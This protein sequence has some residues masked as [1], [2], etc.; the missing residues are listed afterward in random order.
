M[1]LHPKTLIFLFGSECRCDWRPLAR[2]RSP[3][4][5]QHRSLC[6]G[7][8]G[9]YRRPAWKEPNSAF[10]GRNLSRE[11][12]A[13]L[14]WWWRI[15]LHRD[16]ARWWRGFAGGSS[17]SGNIT[18]AARTATRTRRWSAWSWRGSRPSPCTSAACRPK[19]SGPTSTDSPSP[20]ATRPARER[21]EAAAAR[22]TGRVEGRQRSRAGT[23]PW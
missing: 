4:W 10:Y 23:A 20:V 16:T 12:T 2:Q 15:L 3:P 13:S 5:S 8:G 22:S 17:S 21:R 6:K 19:P 9:V 7:R 18:T 1:V 11:F 14:Y